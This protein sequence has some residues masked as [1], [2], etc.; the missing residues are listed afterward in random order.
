MKK[1]TTEC[2]RLPLVLALSLEGLDTG[3]LKE[4]NSSRLSLIIRVLEIRLILK[5]QEQNCERNL[6]LYRR[7]CLS[8]L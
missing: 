8:T 7:D 1:K 6:I 2:S 4:L 5:V 3:S